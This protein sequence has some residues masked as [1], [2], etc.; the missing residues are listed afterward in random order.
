MPGAFGHFGAFQKYMHQSFPFFKGKIAP[1]LGP[2]KYGSREKEEKK[3]DMK[4]CSC[5]GSNP[6]VLSLSFLFRER[7]IKKDFGSFIV[8]DNFTLRSYF[9]CAFFSKPGYWKGNDGLK[10]GCKSTQLGIGK[11]KGR[12]SA[13]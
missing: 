3:I 6:P 7:E 11:G 9:F 8:E 1:N 13:P 5:R 4:I 12:I 2:R 10:T